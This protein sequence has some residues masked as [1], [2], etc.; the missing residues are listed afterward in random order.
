MYQIAP[1]TL[2]PEGF[3]SVATTQAQLVDLNLLAKN[4]SSK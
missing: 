4:N 2:T 3:S 1:K